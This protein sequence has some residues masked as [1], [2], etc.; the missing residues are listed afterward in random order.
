MF[1]GKLLII[2]WNIALKKFQHFTDKKEKPSEE[3]TDET[4]D[5]KNE[6]KG[7]PDQVK[8]CHAMYCIYENALHSL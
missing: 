7:E 8:K 2:C 5:A 1:C 4:S 3:K 6:T